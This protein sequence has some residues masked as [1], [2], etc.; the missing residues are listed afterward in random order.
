MPS[1][2]HDGGEQS[3]PAEYNIEPPRVVKFRH[4]SPL[5]P[6]SKSYGEVGNKS[7]QVPANIQRSSA[8]RDLSGAT[9]QNVQSTVESEE[10]LDKNPDARTTAIKWKD[11]AWKELSGPKHP[12]ITAQNSRPHSIGKLE[13]A[14]K[15]LI[16]LPDISS[17]RRAVPTN[18]SKHASNARPWPGSN[19]SGIF[20]LDGLPSSRNRFAT[21]PSQHHAQVPSAEH[22]SYSLP[23]LRDWPGE[24]RVYENTTVNQSEIQSGP[25]DDANVYTGASPI[26]PYTRRAD[27]GSLS[28]PPGLGQAPQYKGLN[29]M[30]LE[31][32]SVGSSLR[33]YSWSPRL[34][35]KKAVR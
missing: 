26:N 10:G 28:P 3:K 29:Q 23:K 20:D 27:R 18:Q 1:R 2:L 15:P 32:G 33:T 34:S 19:P 6:Q 4:D 5:N 22:R 9:L 35:P 14:N 25:P 17:S 13:N 30:N 8:I 16:P 11:V 21:A 31:L 7:L 24:S 12:E